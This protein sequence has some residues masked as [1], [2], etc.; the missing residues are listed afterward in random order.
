MNSA[1]VHDMWDDPIIAAM[2]KAHS[3]ADELIKN[4]SH[5]QHL[6]NPNFGVAVDYFSIKDMAILK[7]VPSL[8]KFASATHVECRALY[9]RNHTDEDNPLPQLIITH[10]VADTW[11]VQLEVYEDC[12]QHPDFTR[13][14]AAS[15]LEVTKL[16]RNLI[17]ERIRIY[18]VNDVTIPY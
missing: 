14:F 9:D 4:F 5:Y 15:T 11:C 6:D 17:Y 18:D 2:L 8:H 1:N 7:P 3:R 16:L 10:L 12:Q 13:S